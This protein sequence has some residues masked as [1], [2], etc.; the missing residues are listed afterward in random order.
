MSPDLPPPGSG[1]PSS[2]HDLLRLG[3]V[4]IRFGAETLGQGVTLT[5]SSWGREVNRLVADLAAEVERAPADAPGIQALREEIETLRAVLNSPR[6]RHHWIDE[7]LH[8]V[9]DAAQV[10]RGELIRESVYVAEIGRIL[11][12]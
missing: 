3:E 7:G 1:R 6:T 4:F 9:R 5:S 10:V 8:A 2:N 11:G 12:L